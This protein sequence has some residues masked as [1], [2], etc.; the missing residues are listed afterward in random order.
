MFIEL[1]E[2]LRCPVGHDPEPYLVLLADEMAGR[3]VTRGNVACPTCRREYPIVDG[4]VQ[5]GAG[6]TTPDPAALPDVGAIQALLGL[7]GP[8]G[9]VVLLGSA[10]AAAGGLA[11]RMPGIHFVAI[12]APATGESLTVRSDLIHPR[13]IPL[14]TS[15]ARGVVVGQEHST[16]RWLAEAARLVLRGLRLIVLTEHVPDIPRISQLAVGRGMWVGEKT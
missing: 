6:D 15:M 8:G 4:V 9:Y 1:A 5:F 7:G 3:Q 13:V 12:N 16:E 14:R 11:A 10:A 2:F